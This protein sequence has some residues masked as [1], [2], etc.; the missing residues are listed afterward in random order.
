MPAWTLDPIPS[1]RMSPYR[2][3]VSTAIAGDTETFSFAAGHNLDIPNIY[4]CVY[5]FVLA[6]TS[7]VVANRQIRVQHFINSGGA[8]LA[9]G[10]SINY[11]ESPD[12]AASLNKQLLI[13]RQTYYDGTIVPGYSYN[14]G[15]QGDAWTIV[16]DDYITVS[17]Q[18]GQAGDTLR[19]RFV[20]EYM[21]FKL[22]MTEQQ[23]AQG[24]PGSPGSPEPRSYGVN[25]VNWIFDP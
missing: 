1:R 12:I 19:L 22:G 4:K 10:N 11:I 6:A 13:S 20:L 8:S 21:N 15:I 14:V 25:P 18:N 7:A 23:L 16:G 3:F 9:G 2:Q 17:L 24:P 5:L